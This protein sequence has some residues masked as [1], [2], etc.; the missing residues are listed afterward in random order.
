M[1]RI[2]ILQHIDR[3]GPGLFAKIAIERNKSL[4]LYR[5][6]LGDPIPILLDTD[7]LIVMGGPMGICDIN[8]PSYPW[9][10]K[11]IQLLKLALKKQIRVI[12]VCL[13]AQLLAYAA[14]GSVEP[15]TVGYPPKAKLE[16]G[17]G[18]VYFHNLKHPLNLFKDSKLDVLHWHG[19][20]VLLPS[21]AELIASSEVCKEQMFV[22]NRFA[23]GLQFHVEVEEYMALQWIREDKEFAHKAIG[24]N[25][26]SFLLKQQAKFGKE[27]LC[28]RIKF[29]NKIYDLLI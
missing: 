11:E 3:E 8:N 16:V 22:I 26:S 12:G 29:I 4:I 18:P 24:S 19:D 23:Y 17:W 2:I 13:G 25:A 20:R 1:S 6:D 21:E 10:K 9:L 28:D 5:L 15:M 14:G 7:L 27:T